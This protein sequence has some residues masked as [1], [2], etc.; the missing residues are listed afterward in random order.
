MHTQE[1]SAMLHRRE[2]DHREIRYIRERY[3]IE[4]DII[5]RCIY[6]HAFECKYF[7]YREGVGE[8][9]VRER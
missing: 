7:M 4:R 9:R 8:E 2:R 3:I 6:G 5:A 1:S